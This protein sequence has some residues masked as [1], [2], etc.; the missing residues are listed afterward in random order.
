MAKQP[1]NLARYIFLDPSAEDFYV[2]Y[3]LAKNL[4][5]AMLRTTAGRDP[6]D[7]ILS[8]LIGELST[9]SS[10]FSARW[11]KHNVYQHSSGRKVL[12]HPAVGVLDLAFDDFALPGDPSVSICTF[13][14]DPGTATADGLALLASWS[15][16]Q[17][18]NTVGG[19]GAPSQGI[20]PAPSVEE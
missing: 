20:S 18:P 13:T 7:R 12:N 14:A 16:M 1:P 17:Q 4:T 9:R 8:D 19:T 6:L 11:A 10:D 5:V 2:D 3:E 15:Q